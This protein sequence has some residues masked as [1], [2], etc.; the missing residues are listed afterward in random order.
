MKHF[1]TEMAVCM[2]LTACSK[3]QKGTNEERDQGSGTVIDSIPYNS[4]P[5]T[6]ASFNLSPTDEYINV[7]GSA[8]PNIPSFASLS[9]KPVY[10]GATLRMYGEAA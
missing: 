10:S 6:Q 4:L 8:K 2:T 5:Q 9:K 7:M 3:G 1:I